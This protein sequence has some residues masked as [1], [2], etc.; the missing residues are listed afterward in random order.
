MRLHNPK[1]LSEIQ[2]EKELQLLKEQALDKVPTL[3]EDNASL[4]YE[5]MQ[6]EKEVQLLKDDNAS[7]WYAI[8]MGEVK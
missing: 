8:M 1:K 7:L 2:T 6:L 3:E 4:W 5:K